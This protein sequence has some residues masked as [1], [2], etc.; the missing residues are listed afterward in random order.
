[1]DAQS[2]VVQQLPNLNRYAA[3]LARNRMRA[4]DL[5]Q[6]T[7]L[8]ALTRLHHWQDGTDMR[9]W[10]FS[11]M[12]S[13]Y[14]NSVRRG[15]REANHLAQEM[16]A[17]AVSGPQESSLELDDLRRSLAE[18]PNETQA[19]IYLV[20]VEGMSYDQVAAQLQMPVGTLRSRLSRGRCRLR[21]LVDG[22]IT[23]RRPRLSLAAKRPTAAIGAGA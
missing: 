9:A 4:D 23:H 6:D 15:V 1:M 3:Y 18:L 22:R 14:V 13:E 7:V 17:A 11:I 8:R 16:P 19:I 5:V 10:L 2:L 20:T 21:A 12:H